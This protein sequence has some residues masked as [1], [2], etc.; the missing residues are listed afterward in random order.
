MAK[1]FEDFKSFNLASATCSLRYFNS[2]GNMLVCVFYFIKA[3][4]IN[5]V[6]WYDLSFQFTAIDEVALSLPLE[7]QYVLSFVILF[8]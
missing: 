2:L 8:F 3:Q 6:L 1:Q 7:Q 5:Y 4:V